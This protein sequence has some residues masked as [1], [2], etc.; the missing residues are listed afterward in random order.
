MRKVCLSFSWYEKVDGGN[1]RTRTWF[2]QLPEEQQL[3]IIREADSSLLVLA[4]VRPQV[5]NHSACR[6]IN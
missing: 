6:A 1:V 2:S 3:I 4:S 5:T